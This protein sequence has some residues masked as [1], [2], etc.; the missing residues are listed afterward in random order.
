M[1]ID[2]RAHNHWV[3]KLGTRVD[4][5]YDTD[6]EGRPQNLQK[7][8]GGSLKDIEHMRHTT[9]DRHH[10]PIRH[11]TAVVVLNSG[12]C[13]VG[14]STCN[15]KD[16]YSHKIGYTAALGRA[17]RAAAKDGHVAF[18]VDNELEGRDL[19]AACQAHLKGEL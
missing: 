10:R 9:E 13:F 11:H 6:K 5:V 3:E 12:A 15:P 16:Q 8:H 18:W 2:I 1:Y 17:L 19:Y 7:F 4:F 14:R